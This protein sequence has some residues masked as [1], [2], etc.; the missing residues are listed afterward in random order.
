[1]SRMSRE[2]F[3]PERHQNM[4]RI[5]RFGRAALTAVTCAT[6][7]TTCSPDYVQ[8]TLPKGKYKTIVAMGDS[9]TSGEG[10]PPFITG[11]DT[12]TVN[13]CH[14]S[15]NAYPEKVASDLGAIVVNVACSR[16]T[17][18][19]MATGQWN[20]GSQY[21]ALSAETDMVT[22]TIGGNTIDLAYWLSECQNTPCVPGT[23]PF[24]SVLQQL[25]SPEQDE[26]VASVYEEIA[27][28]APNADIYAVGYPTPVRRGG[29]CQ[30]ALGDNAYAI[31]E[32]VEQ[33][34]QSTARVVAASN[35]PRLRYVAPPED[36]SVCSPPFTLAFNIIPEENNIEYF[37]HPNEYGQAR[38][39][40]VVED[41]IVAVDSEA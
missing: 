29:I 7:L 41:A 23:Q 35:N 24:E 13:E 10:N 12:D 16:G 34:N 33:L 30:L 4:R 22:I 6:L 2:H 39:A 15:L 1:M 3:Q 32:V 8:G 37:G 27:K 38:M 31:E 40:L 19:N 26:L 25:Q 20:E 18:Y 14:R 17:P 36:S 9:F 28:R 21:D 11:T 5:V